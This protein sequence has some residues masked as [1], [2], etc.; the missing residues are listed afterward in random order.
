[1]QHKPE[2]KS[3]VV[4]HSDDTK[5]IILPDGMGFKDA[6]EWLARKEE[7][8]QRKVKIHEYVDAYPL[9]GA[10]ALSKAMADKY[11]WTNLVPTPGFFGDEPPGM[12]G[13]RTGPNPEDVVQVPWGRC[14][15]PGIAGY[16]QTGMTMRNG[17]PVFTIGGVVKRKHE[18]EIA[19]IATLTR[20]FVKKE[21]IYR[22][23]AIRVHFPDPDTVENPDD[24]N[25]VFLDLSNV[26][27]EEL[28][29]SDETYELIRT[30]LFT[31][32]ERTQQCRDHQ[33][34]LKRG[35][36]LAGDYGVGKTLTAYVAAKKCQENGWTFIYLDSVQDLGK[37]I[38][39]AQQYAPAMIFAEDI[40]RVLSGNDRGEKVNE[41][42]NT[43]DGVDTKHSELIVALTTNHIDRINQ[44]MLRPGRLDAVI[45]VGPPDADAAIKLVRQYGRGLVDESA[46]L[47]EVGKELSGRIPAVIRE[48]I[49]RAKLGAVSRVD[50]SETLVIQPADL[51]V[52]VTSMLKHLELL[53]PQEEDKRSDIE[54]AA[55][56]LA[57]SID[58]TNGRQ[59]EEQDRGNGRSSASRPRA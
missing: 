18:K 32:I 44:A 17:R 30:N 24:F 28:V 9:D 13:V 45:S 8:D 59:K 35:V 39:F 47:T 29:F 16:I 15:I 6:M 22:G 4:I 50:S 31:P 11:G 14:N 19:D 5:K 42:L 20:E 21:S 51:L 52:A 40:D 25:P 33:I 36:L 57:G 10:L 3:V 1:M 38:Y 56:V 53:K 43:I 48:V 34:P 7:E 2:D 27:P 55:V 58:S 12:V 26:K 41:I 49:E 37:S 54:K 23:K 46:D